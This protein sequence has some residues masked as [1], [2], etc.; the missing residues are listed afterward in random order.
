MNTLPTPQNENIQLTAEL[1]EEMVM[2]Q[3]DLIQWITR[4]CEIEMKDCDDLKEAYL[5]AKAKKWKQQSP[6]FL[7]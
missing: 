7:T 5:H 1:P 3:K 6:N 4:K 2:A